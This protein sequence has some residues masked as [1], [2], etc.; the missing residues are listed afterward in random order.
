[1]SGFLNSEQ[2]QLYGTPETDEYNARVPLSVR[3]ALGAGYKLPKNMPTAP[4]E[5]KKFIQ[6]ISNKIE[7]HPGA[8]DAWARFQKGKRSAEVV[9]LF[10][11]T[12]RQERPEPV[13]REQQQFFS[14]PASE[15]FGGEAVAAATSISGFDPTRLSQEEM[16]ARVQQVHAEFLAIQQGS[17]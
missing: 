10:E 7:A 4:L 2:Q 1:M 6:T 9:R 3:E 5:Q 17:H 13:V 12:L 16:E 14:E 11:D 15:W 8:T